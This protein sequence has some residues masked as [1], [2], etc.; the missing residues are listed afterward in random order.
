MP[1][2]YHQGDVARLSAAFADEGG[3]AADPDD[4]ILKVETPDGTETTYT[5]GDLV[6]DSTGAYHYDL[7][8]DDPGRHWYRFEGTG[9]VQAASEAEFSVRRSVFD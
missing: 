6:K 1:N 4:V 8:V 9:I 2:Y 7:P 3:T 5:I